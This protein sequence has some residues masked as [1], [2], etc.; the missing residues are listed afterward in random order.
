MS[1][2]PRIRL[3]NIHKVSGTPW[4][5]SKSLRFPSS[6]S[7][8]K[9]EAIPL[10]SSFKPKSITMGF[11]QR[12]QP[13]AYLDTLTPTG[14]LYLPK[15]GLNLSTGTIFSFKPKRK[16][17]NGVPG[18]GSYNPK[19]LP[20][21]SSQKVSLKSK[22][23]ELSPK[24]CPSPVSYS[25]KYTQVFRKHYKEVG[26]GFGERNFMRNM[27]TDSPGPNLYT[28]PSEFDKVSKGCKKE[29]RILV[30]GTFSAVSASSCL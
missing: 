13:K 19:R 26:F 10:P 15:G 3:I 2:L 1:D 18:P 23:K 17:D 12:W 22:F 6:E 25:P 16:D 8:H 9:S 28:L 5:L 29:S 30:Q 24:K 7:G 27:E 14:H 4:S 21:K 20:L 11:G